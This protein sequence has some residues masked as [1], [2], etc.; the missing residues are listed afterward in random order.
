MSLSYASKSVSLAE[1]SRYRIERTGLAPGGKRVW[2]NAE[3]KRVVE[4]RTQKLSVIVH[5]FPGRTEIAIRGRRNKLGLSRRT[6]KP[7]ST[8]EDKILRQNVSAM[9]WWQISALMPARTRAAVQGRARLLGLCGTWKSKEPKKRNI[10]LFD[11]V[12]QRAWED[13]IGQTAF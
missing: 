1:R 2:S 8:E 3:D 13:G 10:P 9:N 7:W 12:R 11:A 6:C 4:T 5:L